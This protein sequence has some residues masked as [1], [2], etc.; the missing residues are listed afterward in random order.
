[1][2]KMKGKPARESKS[3]LSS[4]MM[5]QDANIRGKVFGGVILKLVDHAAYVAAA[6]HASSADLVT[7][8]FDKVDFRHPIEIGEL[9]ILE[10]QVHY[11]GRTSVQVGVEIFAEDLNTGRRRH[12]N[13]CLVTFVAV[14]KKGRPVPVPP[15]TPE[16]EEEK[17]LY[18]E[19]EKRREN[20]LS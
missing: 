20:R 9:V 4:L 8:S 17:R 16:T 19:A 5:P 10:A 18:R 7:V 3:T 15:V 11:T 13:S 12:S 1:M 2:S 6:R 14:D